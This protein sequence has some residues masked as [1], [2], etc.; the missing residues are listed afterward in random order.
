MTISIY[1]S[2]KFMVDEWPF[3]YTWLAEEFILVIF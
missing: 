1:I 3:T 2:G